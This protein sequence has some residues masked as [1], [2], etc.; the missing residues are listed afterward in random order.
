MLQK[1]CLL[2]LLL[3][4]TNFLLYSQIQFNAIVTNTACQKVHGHDLNGINIGTGSIIVNASGGRPPYTY[5]INEEQVNINTLPR[6]QN[7]GY[8]PQLFAGTFKITVRDADFQRK[9]TGIWIRST[10]PIP[11]ITYPDY[12]EAAACLNAN[13]SIVV[14]GINGT[15]PYLYSID[16]GGSYSRDSV[17]YNISQG[18][19]M[20]DVK[21]ANG[22]LSVTSIV[23]SF[24]LQHCGMIASNRHRT[25]CIGQ[26]Q[27]D[28]IN[29]YTYDIIDSAIKI[30]YD[31]ITYRKPNYRYDMDTIS[32]LGTGRFRI[33]LWDTITNEHSVS[34]I[35]LG[36]A[37]ELYIKFISVDAACDGAADGALKVIAASGY[38][39]YTYTMDGTNFQNDNTFTNLAAGTYTVAVK[40]ATGAISSAQG[41]VYD[42]C[43]KIT[44]TATDITCP[45]PYSTITATGSK[46]ILPYRFSLSNGP[47]QTSNVFTVF[48]P[49]FYSILITDANGISDS[50]TLFVK[51]KCLIGRTDVVDAVCDQPNGKIIVHIRGGVAPYVF[52]RGTSFSGPFQ[53]DSVFTKLAA[54]TYSIFVRDNSGIYDSVIVE[55]YN[56]K[57]LADLG[58]DTTICSNQSL[59]L[60]A[61]DGTAS[62]LWQD[63]S[64]GVSLVVSK[65]GSYW[66]KASLAGCTIADTINVIYP[67]PPFS[68]GNDTSICNGQ[69]L[70][71]TVPISPA[72]YSWNTGNTSSSLP[73]KTAGLYTV[74]VSNRGCSTSDNIVVAIKPSPTANLGNDTTLCEGKT[75]LLNAAN[76]N[77]TYLWQDA[78][79]APTFM[80]VSAGKYSVTVN[81]QDCMANASVEV[82]YNL[83]PQFSL[84]Q[85]QLICSG[86]TIV[87][88]PGIS[89]VGYLW[90]DGSVKPTYIVSKPGLYYVSVTNNCGVY[91]DSVVISKG[92]C[93]LYLPNSF[94]PNNDGKNDL[95]KAGYGDGVIEYH[96]QIFNRYGQTIFK[97]DNKL[98]GWNGT[99]NGKPQP[100]GNYV[101][102]LK[103]S[104]STDNSLQQL[105]GTVLLLR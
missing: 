55:V 101:W 47:L 69:T 65:S 38:P 31:S 3:F 83:L 49:G 44:V 79:K 24:S 37:C 26:P 41:T 86:A 11:S 76:P 75:L 57:P 95:F 94:T 104:T 73:V 82:K 71:L 25:A 56:K 34:T 52:S 20:A 78:S 36:L 64:T 68:L 89:N 63:G 8:F 35:S 28:T 67:L 61:G 15:P 23:F 27:Q 6:I 39:P 45:A 18:N 33:Y 72:T 29:I 5:E 46:G 100:Q 40:D 92:V 19:Y 88:A 58:N 50:T 90:Q 7:N 1:A 102:L 4:C 59:R 51:E 14:H 70:L 91:K 53:D 43:P 85:D 93:N 13:G 30:S 2:I 99:L 81:R 32:N 9:D 10:L 105:K 16:G 48:K 21:D 97:S 80:V 98:T 22:C 103:Y 74:T 12:K 87:L 96:L 62:Y 42:R 77:S 17:F 60:Y 54:G 84:G 66:V